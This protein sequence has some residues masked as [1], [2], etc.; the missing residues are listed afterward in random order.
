[1]IKSKTIDWAAAVRGHYS[2]H[3]WSPC[4]RLPSAQP[5]NYNLKGIYIFQETSFCRLSAFLFRMDSGPC[6]V[7]GVVHKNGSA[8]TDKEC[9]RSLLTVKA[10]HRAAGQNV[11]WTG[12]L[13]TAEVGQHRERMQE[14]GE[15]RKLRHC[16]VKQETQPVAVDVPVVIGY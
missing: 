1:M 9:V 16:G 8:E 2:R 3:Q 4:A 12:K 15:V 10:F 13:A 7:R 6:A 11:W 5:I 14:H